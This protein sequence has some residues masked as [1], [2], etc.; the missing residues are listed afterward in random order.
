MNGGQAV[1]AAC[2]GMLDDAGHAVVIGQGEGLQT[3]LDGGRDQVVGLIG[4]VEE[5]V[6]GVGVELGI[7]RSR[8]TRGGPL[9]PRQKG[10]AASMRG[11]SWRVWAAWG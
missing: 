7:A 9:R 3:E 8:S 1:G 2:L 6:G 5:G 10:G 11:A 4:P